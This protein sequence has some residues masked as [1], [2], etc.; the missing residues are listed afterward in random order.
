[1]TNEEL[2][3]LAIIKAMRN[4]ATGLVLAVN[5]L[6]QANLDDYEIND[7]FQEIGRMIFSEPEPH[8]EEEDNNE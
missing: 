5:K 2:V 7:L 8:Q 4:D 1:M 3:A 6:R